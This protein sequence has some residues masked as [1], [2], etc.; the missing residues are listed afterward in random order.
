MQQAS[1]KTYGHQDG[2]TRKTS[3]FSSLSLFC[4]NKKVTKKTAKN[5]HSVRFW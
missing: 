4:T 2:Q 1:E 3:L 5:D